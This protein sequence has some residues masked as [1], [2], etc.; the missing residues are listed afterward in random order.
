MM[1]D[2]S[3]TFSR[4]IPREQEYDLVVA[5]GGP[6]GCGA[7]ISAARLGA[8]VLLIEASGCLGGMGTSGLVAAWSHMS[9]GKHSVIGGLMREL[10]ETMYDR[11]HIAPT[12]D[13]RFWTTIYNRGLGYNAEGYKHLLDEWCV[14]AGVEV[15]FF[16]RVIDA[17]VRDRSVRGV[18]IHSIEGYSFV[19]TPTVV[20]ATGDA[21]LADVCG[22]ATRRAGKD[23]PKIM[24]PT[25]C[26]LQTGIDYDRFHRG[27]QQEAVE[28]ALADG[29]FSQPDRHVPGLFRSGQHFATLNAGHLFGTDALDTASLSEGMRKGRRLA[30]EYHAF[31]RK[32]VPGCEEMELVATA[33]A[34]G[35]RE[36]RR[37]VGEYELSEADYRARRTFPDQIAIYCKQT[38]IHVYAP[39]PEEYARYQKEFEEADLLQPG[40]YY[41]IPYGTLVPGGWGNL[42]VAG[43]CV[44]SDLKV[45]GAIRDQP[46][47]LMMGQAAGTA[48]VQALRTGQRADG[49]DTRQLIDALLEQGAN[50]PQK[51]RAEEM[52]RS[53]RGSESPG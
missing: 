36:S 3:Y 42:W 40:E 52:T 5:G 12:Y 43:R 45:N 19:E 38:D 25:L 27:L 20:D 10:V 7:A 24:P 11:G 18:V 34:L 35:V 13:E 17:E 22:A 16:T 48:A 30:R 44:S 1:T 14:S 41:G 33:P 49:L 29:F 47:C 4:T 53:R 26:S 8:K 6:G 21:V 32:Y 2:A 9:N 51:E 23:T 28:R 31:F 37:I 15:R 50:L 39:T 46:A